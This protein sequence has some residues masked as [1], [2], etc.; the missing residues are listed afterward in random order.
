[1]KT[2]MNTFLLVSV[3]LALSAAAPVAENTVVPEE[4]SDAALVKDPERQCNVFG[5]LD[6]ETK[7]PADLYELAD[8]LLKQGKEIIKEQMPGV[9]KCST[10][11]WYQRRACKKI[12]ASL[13]TAVDELKSKVLI[14]QLVAALKPE[15]EKFFESDHGEEIEELAATFGK[16]KAMT[17]G[18]AL[19][20]VSKELSTVV[21]QLLSQLQEPMMKL[22]PGLVFKL[23]PGWKLVPK[24]YKTLIID[25]IHDT[26]KEAAPGAHG[27]LTAKFQE[28][29][30]KAAQHVVKVTTVDQ[31]VTK[32]VMET[33]LIC[34]FDL[35]QQFA[36]AASC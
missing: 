36:Q 2:Y 4:L 31:A 9:L 34:A 15:A 29:A 5:A 26:A 17:K 28:L 32:V 10:K 8:Q 16:A 20:F 21:A 27:K 1:M 7:V 23:I 22:V 18:K 25:T 3:I 30:L 24:A 19:V 6:K 11:G 14:D 12:Q 35:A 33:P 13:L